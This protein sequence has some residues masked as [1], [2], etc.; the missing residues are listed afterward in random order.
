MDTLKH[1]VIIEPTQDRQ[2]A[3][4][5]ALITS[6]VLEPKPEL[7]LFI[8]VDTESTD[9][10]ASNSKLYRSGEWLKSITDQVEAAGLAY[11]YEFCW[12]D[13]WQE[14]VLNCAARFKP[15]HIF[16]PDYESG[17]KRLIYS[18]Q[19][20]ALLRK[21]HVPVTIV[22]PGDVGMRKKMLAA[23]N[24]QKEDD[25]PR[26][27][28]L[29]NK[30]LSQGMDIAERY[31]AEFYVVNAY[32]DS[33]NYPNR[34]ALLKRTGL[35]TQNVHVEEGDPAEVIANYANRVGADTIVIGTL[36]RKGA[37]ALMKGNTSER[38]L[39]RLNQDVITYS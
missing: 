1:L 13:E 7:R 22:R 26:Y 4:E 20:W 14:A 37:M 29:N 15:F 33:L 8:A 6:K 16:M 9:L 11:S 28:V 25:N 36:A 21:S 27:A 34:E 32:K 17:K 24:I 18:S 19:Q 35:P 3:L 5:R 38:V 31:G 2:I 39:R 23:V 30:I 12:S 10:K